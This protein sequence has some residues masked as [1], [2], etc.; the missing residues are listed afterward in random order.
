MQDLERMGV[1][2]RSSE[3]GSVEGGFAYSV[4]L[5]ARRQVRK[6]LLRKLL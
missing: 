5:G 2:Y 6:L 1:L 3:I 4:T